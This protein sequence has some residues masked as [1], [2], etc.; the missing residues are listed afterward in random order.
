MTT[1]SHC[2]A[3]DAQDPLA[4]L[5]SQFALPEGVIYSTVTPWVH[6]RWRRWRGRKR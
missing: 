6:G 3:L 5:R 2:Q 1:R 4:P